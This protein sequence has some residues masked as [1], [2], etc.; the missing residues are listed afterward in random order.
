MQTP[1]PVSTCLEIRE[2]RPTGIQ[3]T[4]RLDRNLLAS[5]HNNNATPA[6][7][8]MGLLYKQRHVDNDKDNT[9]KVMKIAIFNIRTF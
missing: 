7:K 5:R 4:V 3:T 6:P 2:P 9:E 8:D 1:G